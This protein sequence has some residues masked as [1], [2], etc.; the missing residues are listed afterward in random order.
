MKLKVYSERFRLSSSSFKASVILI[1]TLLNVTPL[2]LNAQC[3]SIEA[4]MIDGCSGEANEFVVINSGTNGFNVSDLQ[5]S[6]DMNNNII[7]A[8]NNDININIDN[9]SGNPSPCGLQTGDISLVSGCT[10]VIAAGLGDVIPP[11]SLVILQV[12]ATANAVTDFS[13][14]C[15]AGQ[16][17]YV[18][19][20]SCSRT[21]GGFTNGSGSGG[22]R[23][24]ILDLVS[25]PCAA[26]YVYDRASIV[27]GD[28]AYYLPST[29]TYGNDGCDAPAVTVGSPP[30]SIDPIANVTSCGP[31]TLPNI[32]GTNLTGGEAYY[33]GPNGT[34]T[35]FSQGSTISSTTTLFI[36]D[37]SN[38]CSDQESFTITIDNPVTPNLPTIGPFCST[39]PIEVLPT[40]I[41]GVIGSWSGVGVS[42]G[43][44]FNPTVGSSTLTFT[45]APGECANLPSPISVTVNTAID[46]ILGPFSDLCSS[47]GPITLTTNPIG[48]SGVW[49]GPG[50]SGNLFDPALANI[51]GN[52]ITFTP[53][54]GQC[55]NGNNVTLNVQ[56][57][58][59]ASSAG[60]LSACDGENF[61]LTSLESAINSNPG[62]TFNWSEDIGGSLPI[63][64]PANYSSSGGNV[65]VSV[66]VGSC[67]S[68]TETIQLNI[69]VLPSI[70]SILPLDACQDEFGNATFDLMA[71]SIVNGLNGGNGFPVSFS[72]DAAGNN[73]IVDPSNFVI[74]TSPVTIFAFV[75][76]PVTMCLS[77]AESIVLNILPDPQIVQPSPQE[78]C[79]QGGGTATF[80]LNT[81]N[82]TV[83][84]TGSNTVTWY[85]DPNGMNPIAN[86]GNYNT[87]NTTIYVS[88]SDGTCTSAILALD[89]NVTNTPPINVM[90]PNPVCDNGS[91]QG[92]FDLSVLENIIN[93]GSGEPVN[94]YEDIGLSN[95]IAD[96]S[97]YT[98]SGIIYV[99]VGTGLCL[100]GPEAISLLLQ[101]GPTGMDIVET[102]CGD[103]NGQ[104]TIDLT[105][106]DNQVDGTPGN[107]IT[108]YSDPAGNNPIANPTMFTTGST[109]VY[110]EVSDG[111]CTSIVLA[112]FTI[113]VN[114]APQAFP[115]DP[116]TA[117][118]IFP[119]DASVNLTSVEGEINGETGLPVNWYVDQAA[120]IPIT[121]PG[122][123]NFSIPTSVWAT[124]T[125]PVTGCETPTTVEVM[126][127]L[128]FAPMANNPGT[129]T[130]CDN[131]MGSA[132]FNLA[133]LDGIIGGGENVTYYSDPGL[134]NEIVNPSDYISSGGTVY[135]VVNDGVCDSA[136]EAFNLQVLAAPV[137]NPVNGPNN[138]CADVTNSAIVDLTLYNA[139]VLGAQA[140]TVNWFSDPGGFNQIFP[141]DAFSITGLTTVYAQV[142]GVSCSS[143]LVAVDLNLLPAPD[144]FSDQLNDCPNA[145]GFAT[146]DLTNFFFQNQVNGG[147]G[148]PI[149]FYL[150]PAGMIEI[151]NPDAFIT[152]VNT[153]IFA[154]VTDANGCTSNVTPIDLM[155]DDIMMPNSTNLE[156]CDEG[157]DQAPFNLDDPLLQTIIN[158]NSGL[159]INWYLD[160]IGN[161][162]IN[163]TNA[164]IS[165]TTQVFVTIQGATCESA[166]IP[167]DLIVL[168]V[169][170][171]FP[172]ND[173]LELCD[174]GN[175]QAAF[176]LNA[177][178]TTINGGNGY[179]VNWFLDE[180]ATN[181]IAD[182][183]SFLSGNATVYANT[184]DG[185]CTSEST[186]PVNVVVLNPPTADSI[187]FV[188]CEEG[189]NRA[190]F[191]LSI[192]D[193]VDMITSGATGVSLSWYEDAALSMPIADP[194][195][196]FS[197]PTTIYVVVS[198][199]VCDSAPTPI[200]IEVISAP[201]ILPIPPIVACDEGNGMAFIDLTQFDD[202]VNAGQG[203][204]VNWYADSNGNNPILNPSNHPV[205]NGSAVYASVFSDLTGCES[206]TVTII[207]DVPS[208]VDGMIALVQPIS[209]ASFNDGS[210]DLMVSGGTEPYSYDWNDDNFDGQEDLSNLSAGT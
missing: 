4:I 9:F 128:A 36:Y 101:G 25:Q 60:P 107:T 123:F 33:T 126:L 32:T 95:P 179:V 26:S 115:A 119:F 27:G 160:A 29:N 89:L 196:F 182:P 169:P 16:C 206:P 35:Q 127:A 61:D 41:N 17:A 85:S 49:S 94:W 113:T 111:N 22:T 63:G 180:N 87:A 125:D 67:S 102:F 30:P 10:N 71:N 15:G 134:T 62:V 106:Y 177:L 78:L 84:P 130:A 59:T 92:T 44:L 83:D 46:V 39:D 114:A 131:G 98:G 100:S 72:T 52:T 183:S 121:N 197:P 198:N 8:Q 24:T 45:P 117:C 112:T 79:D 137:A 136:E 47:D 199:G 150:D 116:L 68:G 187:S 110:A 207:I 55:V 138:F 28:G 181:P 6:Y 88:V 175:N 161:T 19:Q 65:Y 140:G 147:T 1:I 82:N 174:E 154:I 23:T 18:I 12:S 176:N 86:P 13:A 31:Y 210:I 204:M 34:G 162:P 77:V 50:T 188:L 11:N 93:G 96:P 202:N 80:D 51:G 7:N 135:A 56:P 165:G 155:L 170:E 145:I 54:A 76:D 208:P 69:D 122:D 97:N 38:T 118:I 120:T 20:S 43:N 203:F 151:I 200:G 152:D 74:T 139:I 5:L 158:G 90:D 148:Y 21:A 57:A 2:I 37:G 186:V 168:D 142:N 144:A 64:N 58:P 173:D 184:V 172:P 66:S 48:V 193:S 40:T 192:Q 201:V 133:N 129:Q 185:I 209:C 132:S 191:D 195:S 166:A 109:V 159:P 156:L 163:N 189:A 73:P 164:Y 205:M 81:L 108:W 153:T 91:G 53:D 3:P 103:T 14:I 75:E 146:F 143:S 104:I 42:N 124:V 178:N 167:I 70:S 157:N 149:T 190:T 171:V 99:T 194:S 141:A 105:N